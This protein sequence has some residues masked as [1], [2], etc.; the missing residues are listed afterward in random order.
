MAFISRYGYFKLVTILNHDNNKHCHLGVKYVIQTM[1][2]FPLTPDMLNHERKWLYTSACHERLWQKI[3]R[4]I[5]VSHK[6]LVTMTK[7][8][9]YH[10]AY[11]ITDIGG[12]EM[13]RLLLIG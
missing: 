4:A 1:Y 5:L 2:T 13:H 10:C 8:L 9:S 12:L 11:D 3:L 7:C 6:I